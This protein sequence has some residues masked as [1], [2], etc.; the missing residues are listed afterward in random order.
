MDGDG[1]IATPFNTAGM[2]RGWIDPAGTVTT[3]ISAAD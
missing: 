2:Y 3:R 1:N